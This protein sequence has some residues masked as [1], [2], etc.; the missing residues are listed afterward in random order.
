MRLVLVIGSVLLATTSMQALFDLVPADRVDE[1]PVERLLANLERNPHDL[2]PANLA[3]AI[4]RVHLLAYLRAAVRLPVL[5]WESTYVAERRIEDCV[6]TDAWISKAAAKRPAGSASAPSPPEPGERCEVPSY[7]LGPRTE[8]PAAPPDAT[9]GSEAHLVAAIEAYTRAQSLE[10]DNL[11]TRVALAFACDR[12]GERERALDHLRFVAGVGLRT[13]VMRGPRATGPD[14]ETHSVVSEAA[15]HLRRVATTTADRQLTTRLRAALDAAPPAMAVTPLL[16][17]LERDERI[18]AL[19][20]LESPVRFDF[21]GLRR[22][23][24][25]GWLTPKAAWLVWDP[26][27]RGRITSG[28]QL[29]GSATWIAFWDTGYD[30]LGTLD[31]NSDGV[32]SGNELTGLALWHDRDADGISDLGEVT[33]VGAHGV[34][35]LG[36]RATRTGPDFWTCEACVTFASGASRRTYDWLLREAPSA[37]TTAFRHTR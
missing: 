20:D 25:A 21:S 33:P 3:R 5:R 4:G 34:V 28:F 1:V 15:E 36:Y 14:W 32:I 8:I 16:V 26:A 10:P 2:A 6:V 7:S 18:D 30:A 31:D 19:T 29:F 23:I 37:R 12:H 17:P 35:S 13:I 11:R 27:V 9:P 22:P 24:R